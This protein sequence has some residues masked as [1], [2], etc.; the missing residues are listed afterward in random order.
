MQQMSHASNMQHKA[1]WVHNNQSEVTLPTSLES[2]RSKI[3]I[4]TPGKIAYK[5]AD[6]R[7]ETSLEAP[8]ESYDPIPIG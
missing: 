1:F 2:S 7:A 3:V 4:N 6:R 5:T 8:R